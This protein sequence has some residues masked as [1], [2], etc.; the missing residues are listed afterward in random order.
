MGKN[1]TFGSYP[2]L[3]KDGNPVDVEITG[4]VSLKNPNGF[5]V[6]IMELDNGNIGMSTFKDG[7]NVNALQFYPESFATVEAAFGA[8]R[9]ATKTSAFK[10]L[11][12]AFEA[13]S[14][15]VGCTPNYK[16]LVK[17]L[18]SIRK[19]EGEGEE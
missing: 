4:A 17:E 7:E 8:F 18:K 6:I 1:K 12:Q 14:M 5:E 13:D 16:E 11:D 2:T 15:Q 3:D 10:V 19:V 9:D